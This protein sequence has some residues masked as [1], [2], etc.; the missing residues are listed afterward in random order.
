MAERERKTRRGVK[1][2]PFY[3]D[4]VPETRDVITRI[5][6][7]TGV[8]KN[9]IVEEIV[10]NLEVDETGVPVWWSHRPDGQEELPLTG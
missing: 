3:V 5:H 9:I 7:A 8:R 1:T 2:V 10:R 6:E 4:V